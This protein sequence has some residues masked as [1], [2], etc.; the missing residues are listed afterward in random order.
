MGK[1]GERGEERKEEENEEGAEEEE[2]GSEGQSGLQA[3]NGFY[4]VFCGERLLTLVV[5]GPILHTFRK[6]YSKPF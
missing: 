6:N 1:E 4:L 5:Q 2:K 3:L